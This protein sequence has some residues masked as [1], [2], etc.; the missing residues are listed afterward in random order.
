MNKNEIDTIR[1]T[2]DKSHLI[3]IGERLYG[4]SI[5]LIRELVNNAYDADASEVK[6]TI[7]ENQIIVEDDGSGM[8]LDGL[9]QYFN[10]GSTLKKAEHRSPKFGRNR[11]GEFGIGKFSALSACPYFEVWTKKGDFQA[12]VVFDKTEWERSG[13][14]WHL[15]LQI[16]D[17]DPNLSD[18]TRITLKGINKRFNLADVERRIIESVPIRAENFAVYLNGKR[19]KVKYI[20]GYRIPFLEGTPY[21]VVHGEIIISSQSDADV[22]EAGISC[23]VKGASIKKDFFGLEKFPQVAA[24]ISEEVC[25]DFLPIT[26]DRTNFIKDSSEY[27]A[28]QKVMQ[29]VIERVKKVLDE[30]SDFKENRRIKKTLKEIVDKVQKALILNPDYCP[31]GFV[32]IGDRRSGVGQAA[33]VSEKQKEKEIVRNRGVDEKP[34]R[35]RKKR[36]QIK[37]LTPSAVVRRLAMGQQ[38]VSCCIDHFGPD[39]PECLTEETIIYINRDHPLYRSQTKKKGA[40]PLYIARL[41]TQEISLMR[42]PRNPRKA[43]KIQSKLLKDA[44]VEVEGELKE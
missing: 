3:T 29:V 18:G 42:N 38:G 37:R 14:K 28:F 23:K 26:S 22:L 9:K 8:D 1:V 10:I 12:V 16:Q 33:Y 15:P 11:I 32:P 41:L 35:K 13:D 7:G 6:I 20:P 31:E 34:K 17:T 39:S 2:V 30:M 5:E 43:Y 44:L 21:G 36:A 19:I 40:Y 27:K 25:V 24:R 4:E